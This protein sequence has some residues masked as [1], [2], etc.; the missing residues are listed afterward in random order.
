YGRDQHPSGSL[1]ALLRALAAIDGGRQRRGDLET[2]IL[3]RI[4]SLEPMDCTGEIV[5]LVAASS[6]FAPHFHLPLQ[7]A[8]NRV[9]S[10]MRRPYT[11]ERYADLVEDIRRRLPHA[12]I[13]SDLIVGFPRETEDDFEQLGRYLERSPLT[14]VHVFP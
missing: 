2:D 13:G 5:E 11:I 7:H 1:V 4:S 8:S 10:A 14:H 9:L 12:S 3:F 6:R